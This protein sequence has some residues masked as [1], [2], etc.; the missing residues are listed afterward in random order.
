[1]NGTEALL[2]VTTLLGSRA[3][4]Y[5]VCLERRRE[6]IAAIAARAERETG[7]PAGLLLVVGMNETHLGCARNEGGGWGAPINRHHRHTAGT[8]LRAAQALAWSY[9]VC[10]TW[11]GAVGRFRSGLCRPWQR[12]HVLSTAYRVRQTRALY[13]LAELPA[14]F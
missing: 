13:E 7:V 4:Q 9:R 14:P 11:E 6:E 1:M 8:P 2:L 12:A 3:W 10:G 5:P